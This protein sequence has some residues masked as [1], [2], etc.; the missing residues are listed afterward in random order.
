[1]TAGDATLLATDFLKSIFHLFQNVKNVILAGNKRKGLSERIGPKL[2]F[3]IS[4][5][6]LAS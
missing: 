3:E 4:Y 2:Q 5:D 6:W 1:M